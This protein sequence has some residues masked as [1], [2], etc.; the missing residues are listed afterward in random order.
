MRNIITYQQYF[1]LH[2]QNLSTEI[3][4]FWIIPEGNIT[5]FESSSESLY[6]VYS[7]V[8]ISTMNR[9]LENFFKIRNKKFLILKYS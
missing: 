5:R 2:S 4:N 7:I 9:H 3:S 1:P 8:I 6:R